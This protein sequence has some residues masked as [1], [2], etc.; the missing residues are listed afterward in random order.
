MEDGG[1][2]TVSSV[3]NSL[4]LQQVL[5]T[6]AIVCVGGRETVG[7]NIATIIIIQLLAMTEYQDSGHIT[8]IITAETSMQFTLAFPIVGVQMFYSGKSVKLKY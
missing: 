6:V 1:V 8:Q 5:C 7:N 4:S 3:Y 2:G